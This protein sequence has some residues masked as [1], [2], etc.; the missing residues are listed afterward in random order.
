M[1]DY[2]LLENAR[3]HLDDPAQF[4]F[5]PLDEAPDSSCVHAQFLTRHVE[6]SNAL[7]PELS[8]TIRRASK[9]LLG[10]NRIHAFIS[11][12]ETMNAA[13][14]PG[15]EGA[16]LIWLSS[17]LIKGV[18]SK[19]LPF[20]IGHEIGHW[21][22]RHYLYPEIEPHAGPRF[23]ARQQLSRAAEISCDRTGLLA[24]GDLD[25]ALRAIL[26]TA[27]GLTDEYISP[28]VS[29]YISQARSLKLKSINQGEVFAT[30][31]PLVIRARALLWFSMSRE[32]AAIRGDSAGAHDLAVVN[33]RVEK[34]LGSVLG[35]GFRK[36]QVEE[37]HDALLWMTLYELIEDGKLSKEDQQVIHQ[38]FGKAVLEKVRAF[39]GGKTMDQ[40]RLEIRDKAEDAHR[41]ISAYPRQL[42]QQHIA[43]TNLAAEHTLRFLNRF[44]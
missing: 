19:E 8:D 12:D 4:G 34:D 18:N 42:V 31:P 7:F 10:P 43:N 39:V 17:G 13:C 29:E 9:R 5:S 23:V 2:Q 14:V 28:R 41:L 3:F 6:V 25:V 40:V 33:R 26:K 24:C 32:Y 20:I 21:Y 38:E 11:A 15:P 30:H 1:P 35:E 36:K 37:I 16:P 27:S 44:N 22:Y